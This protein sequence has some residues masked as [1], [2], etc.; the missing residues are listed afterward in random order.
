MKRKFC[1][2]KWEEYVES[3]GG[4]EAV[5]NKCEESILYDNFSGVHFSL[6]AELNKFGKF[7]PVN[8]DDC[9]LSWCLISNE[10]NIS[11][12]DFLTGAIVDAKTAL[13]VLADGG[14]LEDKGDTIIFKEGMGIVALCMADRDYVEVELNSLEYEVIDWGDYKDE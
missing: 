11:I 12:N 3:V 5:V 7:D 8:N 13:K 6:C 10:F 9:F 2:K 4:W 14:E 1:Q